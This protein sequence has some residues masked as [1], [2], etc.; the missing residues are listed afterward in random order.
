MAGL[1]ASSTSQGLS[2]NLLRLK[3]QRRIWFREQ[4]R[5]HSICEGIE[6]RPA[7]GS[8]K[9]CPGAAAG[10]SVRGKLKSGQ[11]QV[12][13]VATV[14]QPPARTP[15]GWNQTADVAAA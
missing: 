12:R 6:I 15:R 7:N 13:S 1:V 9:K 10:A 4:C 8:A 11:F 2:D 5:I 14:H 3:S